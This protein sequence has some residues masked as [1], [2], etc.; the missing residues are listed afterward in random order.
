MADQN[1]ITLRPLHA[2][3][4]TIYLRSLP[5]ADAA[6]GTKIYLRTLHAIPKNIYMANPRA[7]VGAISFPTQFSG[8][9]YFHGTVRELCMVAVADAP[10][11]DQWR[12]HKGG[13]TYAVYLVD[14]TDPNASAVRVRTS[15]GT[16]SARLKT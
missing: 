13:T 9:R 16:R 7:A 3:P 5:V 14:T 15:G 12:V 6:P 11:G 2:T 4:K 8:L 10:P 1:K